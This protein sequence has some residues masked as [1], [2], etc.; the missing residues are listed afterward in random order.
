MSQ[1]HI[2]DV[3]QESKIKEFQKIAQVDFNRR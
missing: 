1:Q 2:D 3:Y